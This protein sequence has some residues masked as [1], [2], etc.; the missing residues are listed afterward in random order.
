[1]AG[2]SELFAENKSK[3]PHLRFGDEAEECLTE[4][5]EAYAVPASEE[6][7]VFAP[8][9]GT[10]SLCISAGVVITDTALYVH[11]KMVL[12]F[13]QNRILLSELCQYLFFQEDS[14][15]AVHAMSQKEDRV[16]FPKT[17]GRRNEAGR[18]LLRLLK[19]FQHNLIAVN[20]KLSKDYD[21]ALSAALRVARNCFSEHG[22]L[23]V[24]AQ[25]LLNLVENEERFP[26]DV[27][28]IRAENLYRISDMARYYS[29]VE[30]MQGR[31]NEDL[32]KRLQNPDQAFFSDFVRD[33]SNPYSLFLTQDL[34]PSYA[35]LRRLTA[36]NEYQVVL[37]GY[38]SVRI[39]DDLLLHK[40]LT[41]H[42][43]EIGEQ[44]LWEIMAF[45]ARFKNEKMASIYNRLLS[46]SPVSPTERNW[47][48]SLGFT[49][50]HYALLLR[51]RKEVKHILEAQDW[52]QFVLPADEELKT[53]YDFSFLAAIIYDHPQIVREVFLHTSNLVKPILKAIASLEQKIYINQELGRA[54]LVEEYRE[55][56][57]D[58]EKEITTLCDAFIARSQNKAKKFRENGSPLAKFL[59]GI[60]DHND[61]LFSLLTGT[62]SDYRVYRRNN[63]FFVTTTET[64]LPFSYYE[65][66]GQ[67]LKEQN[68]K[69]GDELFQWNEKEEHEYKEKFERTQEKKEERRYKKYSFTG[70]DSFEENVPYRAPQGWF[71]ENARRDPD[72]L[73]KEYRILVKKYHPDNSDIPQANIILQQ[74]MSER[75]GILQ[76]LGG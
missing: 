52:S 46:D 24:K 72:I 50:L 66:R 32:I 59:M 68:I 44:Q 36:L 57:R 42:C 51:N 4:D 40:L 16:I 15:D 23:N 54:G 10:K 63:D 9:D 18:E 17:S 13:H 3:Y 35:N 71:S 14:F 76:A 61:A 11:P 22:V 62:I 55:K 70:E 30:E 45:R 56:K 64:D 67:I 75:S 48:D 73:K 39:D 2:F 12:S 25:M 1:M 47:T 43:R 34:L 31:V 26:V 74:I 38:L 20:P 8:T 21:Q 33:I 65:W 5:R 41:D 49:T 69:P 19:T 28:F 60:Y 29:F 6:I 27:T 37:L 58:M 7:L 53:I